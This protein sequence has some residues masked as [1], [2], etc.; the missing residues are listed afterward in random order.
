MFFFDSYYYYITVALQAICVWHCI[1]KGNQQKW[2]WIIVFLPLIGCIVYFF[3]EIF[4]GNEAQRVSSGLGSALNPGGHIRRL[5]QQLKFADTFGNRIALAD[6]YLAAGQ[7]EKAIAL[8]EQS[9]N[10]VFAENE[11]GVMQL[12]AAYAQTRQYDKILPLA[13]K[14]YNSPQFLRSPAHIAYAK[15]LGFTGHEA[16]AEKEFEKMRSR[17]SAF[18]SRYHYGLFLLQADRVDE[19]RTVF[20]EMLDEEKHLSHREKRYHRTW[21]FKSKEELK[22]LPV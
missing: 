12:M 14:V 1:K 17:F 21:F 15:A 2:I 9:L 13:K 3:T 10:G 19:A 18:E 20:E 16:Q 7:T 5:E 4:T 11:Y 6:A 8:Y 22:K